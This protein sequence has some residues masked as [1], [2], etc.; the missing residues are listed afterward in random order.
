MTP[1]R[2]LT[3]RQARDMARDV[4][5]GMSR[6]K[7]AKK[8]KVSKATITNYL[9]DHEY[10]YR[11]NVSR[12]LQPCGTNAGYAR[13]MRKKES[14]C[15]ECYDAHALELQRYRRVVRLKEEEESA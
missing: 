10:P 13:H 4:A 8:Y 15:L 9:R 6:S 5:N 3:P 11:D 2:K 7:A 14:P 1:P 12:I